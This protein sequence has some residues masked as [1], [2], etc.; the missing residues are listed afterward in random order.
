M[1][2]DS[3]IGK[4]NSD[5]YGDKRDELLDSGIYSDVRIGKNPNMIIGH[6]NGHT[7]R[8]RKNPW[9][10]LEGD[11]FSGVY[12][13]TNE[14]DANR[15]GRDIKG[16]IARYDKYMNNA[17]PYNADYLGLSKWKIEQYD[18]A[19]D[20]AKR[21]NKEDATKIM[22]ETDAYFTGLGKSKTWT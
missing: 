13:P 22:D 2:I 11:T 20:M 12:V 10:L 1:N 19:V 5:K 9:T 15:E 8:S 14:Y 21:G 7:S 18:K 3:V 4:L 16:P 6:G 17:S